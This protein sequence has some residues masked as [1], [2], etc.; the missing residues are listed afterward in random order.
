MDFSAHVGFLLHW[1]AKKESVHRPARSVIFLK[2][3]TCLKEKLLFVVESVN[4]K[5]QHFLHRYVKQRR[6]GTPYTR[7]NCQRTGELRL[8]SQTEFQNKSPC[9]P[10]PLPQLVV[11]LY[12]SLFLY[13]PSLQ[14]NSWYFTQ[15]DPTVETL[16][17][18]SEESGLQL[19][20]GP[21]GEYKVIMK[22]LTV[23][24]VCVCVCKYCIYL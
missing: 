17:R 23:V 7:M 6:E 3:Q 18:P 24:P 15:S 4:M 20:S 16:R 10:P 1:K 5:P 14:T 13:I 22:F 19:S 21:L 9:A 11:H 2:L 8:C 12:S